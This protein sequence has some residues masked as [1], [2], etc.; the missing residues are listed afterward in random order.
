MDMNTYL[1]THCAVLV[2][3]APGPVC[4]N[5]S[6]VVVRLGL[7]TI[8]CISE[9]PIYYCIC[10]Y[11]ILFARAQ[12]EDQEKAWNEAICI[13]MQRYI[14][15]SNPI[16]PQLSTATVYIKYNA[17]AIATDKSVSLTSHSA[18]IVT[19]RCQRP[20]TN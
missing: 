13:Y 6:T 1:Y 15:Y 20:A 3:A 4:T 18:V 9:A 17:V 16:D 2:L 7:G 12:T 5:Q 14:Q 19:D 8:S 10:A 11:T